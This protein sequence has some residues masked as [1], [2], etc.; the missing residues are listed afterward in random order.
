VIHAISNELVIQQNYLQGEEIETIYLGGGTPSLLSRGEF[1]VIL[2]S[3]YKHYSINALPEITLEANP[4][5]LTKEKIQ[6]LKEV[7]INRVSL[8]IQSFDDTI[9]KFLNRAHNSKEALRCVL[10]LREAGIHNLSIDLIHSIPG[11]DDLR[12]RQNLEQVIKLA[13]QHI[14]VYSLTIED[15]TVFGKWASR[16]K[17]TAVEESQSANQFEM[18]MDTLIENGYQHYEISNFCLPGFAS[19]HNSSYW[20]QKKYLGVGP[21]AHSFDGETRQF[22]VSN[23]HLYL[24]SLREGK[25]S[26]EKEILSLENKINE[27]LFTSL[28][29]DRGCNLSYLFNTYHYD[30]KKINS[31]YIQSLLHEGYITLTNDILLL[32]RKGKLLADKIAADLFAALE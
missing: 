26:F 6:I 20:Q 13:P 1:D 12:L 28:R 15:K 17:I 5:D 22:N 7:G 30:L 19:K 10:H 18:V 11:Q 31:D 16:G 14:S 24:N 27:Y 21:S 3:I 9:L 8:G 23:N 4:D 25:L 32:T 2:N 29:T